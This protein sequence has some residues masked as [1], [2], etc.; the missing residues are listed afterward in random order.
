MT[1]GASTVKFKVT[2]TYDHAYVYRRAL[3]STARHFL[4]TLP[5]AARIFLAT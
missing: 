1:E 4:D 2:L 3:P 5:V